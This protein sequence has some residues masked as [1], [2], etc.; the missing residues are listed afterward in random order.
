M[1]EPHCL[2]VC[3][4][5]PFLSLLLQ[6]VVLLVGAREPGTGQSAHPH[7]GV[8]VVFEDVDLEPPP[9]AL[10]GVVRLDRAGL[11]GTGAALLLLTPAALLVGL[12]RR[13]HDRVLLAVVCPGRRS[14]EHT[15]ELQSI[16]RTSYAVFCLKKKKIENKHY[17]LHI[18]E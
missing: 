5:V 15:S 10:V 9:L 14:E 2:L 17:S 7:L 3:S 6:C 8:L 13:V 16:M 4:R 12:L 18:D 11:P 1:R